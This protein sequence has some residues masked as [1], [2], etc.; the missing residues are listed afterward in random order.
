MA[1]PRIRALGLAGLSLVCILAFMASH[2]PAQGPAR[3]GRATKF[4]GSGGPPAT[5][6]PATNATATDAPQVVR[7]TFAEA[8]ARALSTSKLLQAASLNAE[9]KA[10]A[11]R[12]MQAMYFPQVSGT[13]IYL[14]FQD[15]LGTVL[16]RGGRTISG[17]RGQ[18]LVTFPPTARE[19]A[20]LNQDT[21]VIGIFAAQPITDLLKVKQG[22][23]IAQADQGIAQAQWDKGIRDLA[24]GV[25][26]L[27]WGLVAAEKL[28]AG[29]LLGLRAAEGFA[30]KFKTL[31]GR[32]AVVEA[33]QDLHLVEKQLADVREQLNALLDLP[34]CTRVELEE[35][36]LPAFA[37]TCEEAIGLALANSPEIREAQQTIAKAD[38]AVRAGRLDYV[39]SL[40]VVG[41]YLNQTGASYMQ[42]D[43][44]FVGAFANFT[45]WDW[46][47]RKSVIRERQSLRSAASWKLASTEDDVRQKATKA[48]RELRE[49]QEEVKTSREMMELREEVQKKAMQGG[50]ITALRKA[51]RDLA[52]AQVSLVKGELA[53]RQ[54]YVQLMA[55]INE[56]GSLMPS[57]HEAP[58][59]RAGHPH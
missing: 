55:L 42:Q 10:Y 2:L 30:D 20:V 35:P 43:I 45:I 49:T 9:S 14:H 44:G 29:V 24:S 50:D 12:A 28:R 31:E 57:V 13:A 38:A 21:A 22:V 34:L 47:K 5:N 27:C 53:F 16:S 23:R 46:G 40:A 18:P 37:I 25:E 11:I 3:N 51:S 8:K 41:G 26:Q 52:E 56:P 48:V 4:A 15:P 59:L 6:I 33:R 36:P 39:P 17:P 7:L 54:A 32:L 1:P 19:V 58:G